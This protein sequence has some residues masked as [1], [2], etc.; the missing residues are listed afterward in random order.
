MRK[1]IEWVNRIKEYCRQKE[2]LLQGDR[3]LV[4]LSGGADSVCLFLV[5]LS[6][7]KE[8]NLSLVP[9]HVNHNI[10]GE[11][12]EADEQFCKELCR[13]HGMELL[14]VSCDVPELAKERGW[15]LEEAGRN[16][17]YEA[18]FGL[19]A[20]HSCHRIAVA[21]HQNDQAETVLFQMFRGSRIRGLAGMDAKNGSIIRPLLNVTRTEIENYLNTQGQSYCVDRTNY[22]DDY[23]RNKIRNRILPLAGEVQPRAV[24]HVAETAEYLGRVEEFLTRL[25]DTLFAESVT[26][27]GAN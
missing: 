6:L 11:E 22:E 20:E 14:V 18:F 25:T 19:A 21:H 1:E 12:A 13:S 16:A 10:R 4:G 5:L 15:S 3:V 26:E 27:Y 23:T 7:A 17:R 8:W 2:L 24:E 9:V